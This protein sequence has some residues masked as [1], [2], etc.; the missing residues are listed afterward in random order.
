MQG[1]KQPC[2]ST[3][4]QSAPGSSSAAAV[5]QPSICVPLALLGAAAVFLH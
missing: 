1:C 2:K 4:E 3:W 5:T